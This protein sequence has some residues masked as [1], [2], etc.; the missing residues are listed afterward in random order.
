MPLSTPGR[1]NR[2]KKQM[3][4]DYHYI[5]HLTH[6]SRKNPKLSTIFFNYRINFI[7]KNDVCYKQ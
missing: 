1:R 3:T 2:G 4:R 6:E 5:Q 7:D